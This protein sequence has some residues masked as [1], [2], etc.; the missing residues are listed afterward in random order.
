MTL[1]GASGLAAHHGATSPT[2]SVYACWDGPGPDHT[3]R[4]TKKGGTAQHTHKHHNMLAP[5]MPPNCHCAHGAPKDT[6]DRGC[7]SASA[8]TTSFQQCRLWCPM[9][10]LGSAPSRCSHTHLYDVGLVD[11][12][13]EGGPTCAAVELGVA[14]EQRQV[15]HCT[16]TTKPTQNTKHMC[17]LQLL[18]RITLSLHAG[19]HKHDNGVSQ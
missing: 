8:S 7:H 9:S 6:M 2:H 4:W 14:A 1:I 5:C 17:V 18:I 19:G 13:V 12:C 10:P 3:C 16:R 15:T 11:G